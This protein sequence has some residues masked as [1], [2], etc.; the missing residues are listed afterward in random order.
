MDLGVHSVKPSVGMLVTKKGRGGE[1]EGRRRVE[2]LTDAGGANALSELL[3]EGFAEGDL[4]FFEDAVKELGAVSGHFQERDGKGPTI[5]SSS[6]VHFL[7]I[8]GVLVCFK[9]GDRQQAVSVQRYRDKHTLGW[10]WKREVGDERLIRRRV[11]RM[12][13]GRVGDG[14]DDTFLYLTRMRNDATEAGTRRG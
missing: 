2:V 12:R 7:D 9:A 10:S 14:G 6:G 3:A 8:V 13:R 5:A 4:A 11:L 1:G